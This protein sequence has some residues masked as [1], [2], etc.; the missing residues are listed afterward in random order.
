[1]SSNI[2]SWN[3][4]KKVLPT[5][6]VRDYIDLINEKFRGGISTSSPYVG[7]LSSLIKF[8]NE[9]SF[10]DHTGFDTDNKLEESDLDTFLRRLRLTRAEQRRLKVLGLEGAERLLNSKINKTH[11]NKTVLTASDVKDY[12]KIVNT[13]FG[14][15]IPTDISQAAQQ[16]S[17]IKFLNDNLF[18]YRTRFDTNTLLEVSDFDKFFERLHDEQEDELLRAATEQNL[19]ALEDVKLERER[20]KQLERERVEQE[21]L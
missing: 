18:V 14:G 9:N 20:A 4:D 5:D 1:M 3:F 12:I 2:T 7:Q 21:R 16:S 13:E 15:K 10:V 6:I 11:F 17:L 19:Y 8:L